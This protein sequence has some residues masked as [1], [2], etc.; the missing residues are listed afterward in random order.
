[1]RWKQLLSLPL[2]EKRV[3]HTLAGLMLERFGRLPKVGEHIEY[4]GWRFE[5]VDLDGRRID[6]VMASRAAILRRKASA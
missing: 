1:M 6:K 4:S 5:I 3:Y 2:P